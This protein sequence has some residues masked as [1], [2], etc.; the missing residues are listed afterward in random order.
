MERTVSSLENMERLEP[1]RVLVTGGAGFIGAHLVELLVRKK[2]DVTV[3]D[4]QNPCKS[5]FFL[6]SLDKKTNYQ[7][8]DI[9]K[10]ATNKDIRIPKID[11][12]TAEKI[13]FAL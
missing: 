5:Y 8:I 4:I 9:T 7:I 1:L 10:I 13:I 2:Y 3:I 12:A 11:T 6:K